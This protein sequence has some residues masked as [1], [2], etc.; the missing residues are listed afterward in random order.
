[1][2]NSDI[3]NITQTIEELKKEYIDVDEDILATSTFGYFGAITAD[4][5]RTAI[6]VNNRLANEALP[7]RATLSRNII[8]HS[9]NRDITGITAIPPTIEVM[10]TLDQNDVLSVMKDSNRMIIDK[11][12]KIIIGDYE[13]H[14][15]YD[16]IISKRELVNG[17]YV[18]SATYDMSKLNAIS[19]ITN[20]YVGPPNTIILEGQTVIAFP[21]ILRQVNRNV[22][23]KKFISSNLVENKSFQFTFEDQ[24]ADFVIKITEGDTVK[25]IDAIYKGTTVNTKNDYCYYSYLDDNRIRITFDSDVYTPKINSEMEIEVYTTLGTSAEFQY[26]E[27]VQSV[28][29]TDR[30]QYNIIALIIPTSNSKGAVDR[31]TTEQ[32]KLLIPQSETIKGNIGNKADL[33]S[34]FNDNSSKSTRIIVDSKA[35]N[36]FERSYYTYM[37]MKDTSS[38]VI[39]TNTIDLKLSL[40]DF[41]TSYQYSGETRYVLKQGCYILHD[42][43]TAKVVKNPTNEEKLDAKFIYTIPFMCCINKNLLQASY[44]LPM[45]NDRRQI[46]FEYINNQSDLQ[47]ILSNLAFI[48]NYIE[49]SDTYKLKFIL[50]QNITSDMG[51]LQE[52]EDDKGNKQLI[53]NF[54]VVVLIYNS[55]IPYRW[56]EAKLTNYDLTTYKYEFTVEF[57]SKDEINE[58]NYIRIENTN[59]IG[60]SISDYGFFAP[61]VS[62]KIYVAYKSDVDNGRHDLDKYVP[63]LYEYTVSNSYNIKGGLDFLKN[64]SEIINTVVRPF[65][66]ENTDETV[67]NGYIIKSLPVVRKRYLNTEDK[68]RNLIEILEDK[69]ALIRKAVSYLDGFSIDLKFIN[70]YGSSK[71]Y[72]A[73]NLE[74]LDRVNISLKFEVELLPNTDKSTITFIKDDIKKMVEDINDISTIH[75]SKIC[76]TIYNNY[77]NSIA[78]ID[79]KGYNDYN[80]TIKKLQ[81]VENEESIVPEFINVEPSSEDMSSPDISID[82]V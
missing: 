55:D 4:A 17:N 51:V 28:L 74:Y 57:K 24:L 73:G 18:F 10:I 68:V 72:M 13:F 23:Y 65:T 59:L 42:G 46:E 41:D 80:E 82:L 31:K 1:M 40:E 36:Q 66:E 11:A 52:V 61:T 64:Y 58:N 67:T 70:S 22:E 56:A 9:I 81:L 2:I 21:V 71:L 44:Y 26:T 76:S 48:R 34:Y 62:A 45:I 33:Q 37:L 6:V 53:N 47:F 32:L 5:L 60:S 63:G 27:N 19:D 8:T 69:K 7:T 25:Y 29:N 30:F 79:F 15:D 75:A 14:L 54:K 3:Y 20:P 78:Y 49:D 77:K 39:P 12:W 35:D 38:D 16:I 43:K 50:S